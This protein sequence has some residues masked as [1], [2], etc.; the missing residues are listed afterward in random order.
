[1]ARKAGYVRDID[2]LGRL[3]IPK[4]YRKEMDIPEEG[5]TVNVTC[6]NGVVTVTKAEKT[7][8]FCGETNDLREFRNRSVC[9]ECLAEI[10]KI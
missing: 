2:A 5:G 7:C 10:N 6:A 3:V 8:V 1:M 9:P 4:Q